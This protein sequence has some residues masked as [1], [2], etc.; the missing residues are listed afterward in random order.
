MFCKTGGVKDNPFWYEQGVSKAQRNAMQSMMPAD[1]IANLI[2]EWSQEGKIKT[3]TPTNNYNTP[4]PAKTW[5]AQA[6][7][8][9][10]TLSPTGKMFYAKM[11]NLKT[12]VEADALRKEAEASVMV[13][14]EKQLIIKKINEA[15]L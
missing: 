1:W 13:D 6:P 2:A 11:K 5:N 8:S 15:K 7:S 14:K 4:A 9:G 10:W 3:I 12:K